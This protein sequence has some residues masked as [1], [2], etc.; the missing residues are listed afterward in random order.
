MPSGMLGAIIGSIFAAVFIIRFYVLNQFVDKSPLI[1]QTK[2]QFFS[3]YALVLL[4]GILT[5]LLNY[6]VFSVPIASGVVFF[7]GFISFGFF[8]AI[9]MSLDTERRVIE[10]AIKGSDIIN[11]PKQ[12]YPL[13]LRKMPFPMIEKVPCRY[14]KYLFPTHQSL[15]N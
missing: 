10:N 6:F 12:F 1:D 15:M 3:E 11:V 14:N 2:K 4:A 9:D 13:T 8:I 5:I 7:I